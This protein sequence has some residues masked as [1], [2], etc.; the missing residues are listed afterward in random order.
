MR[1]SNM[2]IRALGSDEITLHRDVR[3]RALQDAPDSFGGTMEEEERHPLE[4]W[5]NQTKAVSG[6]GRNVM[7][8]ACEGTEILGMIYGLRDRERSDGARVGGMWVESSFRRQG[9]GRQMLIAVIDWARERS[10]N[11]IGL[12]APAHSVA[13]MTLYRQM[14]FRETGTRGRLRAGSELEILEMTRGL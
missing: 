9:A 13:A 8:L 2:H 10:L 7:F 4:Y 3:L 11:H 12:W 1:H 14:G 6:A 5:E